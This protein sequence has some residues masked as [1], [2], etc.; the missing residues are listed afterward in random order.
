MTRHPRPLPGDAYLA[1]LL[2]WSDEQ[3]LRYQIERQLSAEVERTTNPPLATC[4]PGA[5]PVISLALTVLSVG[6]SVLSLLLAP[7]PRRPGEIITR[8]REG[9][10]ITDGARYAPR[11]GFDSTQEVARLGS[12]IPITFARREFLPA[13]NGRPEG[14]Y[15]GCRVD[16]GLVWSQLLSL[17]GSQMFR[18]VYVLGEGPMAEID[19]QGF[20][21]GNNP[22]RSYDLGTAGANEAAA[23]VTIY[24]RLGGGRIRSSNRIA[25]RLPGN[26]IGN[27]ENQGGGDVFQLRSTGGVIRPDACA[28][29][30]PSSS[31][32]CGLFA[33]IGNGMG[34]RVNP[35]LRPTR[36][37]TTKPS[38]SED[39]QRIDPVDDPVALGAIW[40][41][42]RMWSGRSGVVATS[43]GVTSGAAALSEGATFDYLLSNTTDALTKLKFN[44]T[45]TDAAVDHTE[46]C[47]D[48]AAAISGRQ[49]S[50]DDALVVGD[51][52][53]CGNCL[54]VLEQ[55]TPADRLFSSDADNQPVGGGQ[56]ITVRFRVVRAGTVFVTPSAE[57]NPPGTGTTQF[58]P[59]VTSN[60][61]WEW[62]AIDP[63]PRY[64]TGTS[65]GHL[66]RIA[67]ADFTLARPARLVEIGLRSTLGIRGNGFANLRQIPNLRDIN[68]LAGGER[69]GEIIGPGDKLA[70]SIF[71]SGYRSFSEERYAFFRLSYRAEAAAP[72]VALPTIYGVRGLTQQAQYNAL[73]LE[74][75]TTARWQFRL[76]P[77]SGWEIRSGTAT[78]QLAVLD[79]RLTGLQTV[80]D[81][82]VTV[83]YAGEAP[84]TRTAA[85]FAMD[86]IEPDDISSIGGLVTTT[87]AS[88]AFPGTYTNVQLLQGGIDKGGRATVVVSASGTFNS[89][90]FTITAPGRGYNNNPITLAN[91]S[92]G[93]DGVINSRTFAVSSQS[94]V[95]GGTIGFRLGTIG[96]VP[97]PRVGSR[98]SL[99]TTGTLPAGLSTGTVYFVRALLAS[100][101]FE[102]SLTNGG[103]AVNPTNAGTGSITCFQ[104]LNGS[105]I[106][107]S[108]PNWEGTPAL[109][110]SDIGIGWTDGDAVVDPWGKVAEAFVYDEIQSSATNGPEHEIVYVNIIQT[111]P[112]APSYSGLALIGMNIRSAL[113][114]QSLNQLS[115][116]VL[117]GHICPTR[118]IE[119]TSGPS[120]LLPDIFTRLAL[121]PEFGAGLD[122]SAEQINTASFLAAAQWCFSRRYFF[123]GT[124]P[125]PQNLRQWAGDQASLHLLSFYELNGQFYFKPAL[126]FDPVPIVDL[127]TAANIQAGSFQSTT[128]DDDQRRP[129][130]VT[131]LFRD[132]RANDDILAPGMFATVR[133]ITIREATASDSDPVEQLDISDSCTNRW[134]LID[135]AKFLVRYRRLVG[136]PISFETT[137]AGLLRPI[138]PEDHIAVAYDETLEDLYSNGAVL[139]DGTLVATEPLDDGTYSVL[140]WDGTTPPGPT[141][142]SLVVSEGG[143]RGNLLGTVWTRTAAPQVR[144]YR[145]MRVSPTDDGRQ[146][147]EAVLMPTDATGRLLIAADWDEPSAWVIRG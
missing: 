142:Q 82:A 29:A 133:E 97:P 123:D 92:N 10:T 122:V 112:V 35:Q 141:I 114:F 111:N 49:R 33:T 80:T 120:H 50:A 5:L 93:S 78:G 130:Q 131:G 19:P 13:L 107:G 83:R 98:V 79:G 41:A 70:V 128:T 96:S 144:T 22:L 3:L 34:Y 103:A 24:S 26:D 127:F 125:A 38:G 73:Q 52:F 31:T 68:R 55:R 32:A 136:D 74:M 60:V 104:W 16:L 39:D 1:E 18:G 84:F 67:I 81:G 77:I 15:G 20:A 126:S 101:R 69:D 17:G 30:R 85:R 108:G 57:I 47:S 105:I 121:S 11:P 36:Q 66:H 72:F 12:V 147:I 21:V 88:G 86:S 90:S 117:G 65:R 106:T 124:L 28:A 132:E 40:K 75:P 37:I 118:Y 4:G 135:A 44:S 63:G 6:Y 100:N 102:L 110:R 42:R 146:R 109:V 51:L 99:T 95:F 137:Y 113:E 119:G 94:G 145:V 58:P 54:A 9:E 45:N 59:R 91:G 25:G 48:V 8:Q 116:Q 7:K 71:Q 27:A 61:D 89:S 115:A 139:D 2:G 64:A 87:A 129:I 140:A 62:T 134:H 46:T 14:F 23:R 43:T 76:E 53:K 56:T 143:T 138:A